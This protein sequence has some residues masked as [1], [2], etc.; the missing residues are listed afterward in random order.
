MIIG[1]KLKIT[2][3]QAAGNLPRKEFLSICNSLA[4]AV[5]RQFCANFKG[6]KPGANSQ[7]QAAKNL[8]V[9]S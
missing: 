6:Q 2:L 1:Y 5:Q 7:R 8:P 9:D 3:Q 4:I